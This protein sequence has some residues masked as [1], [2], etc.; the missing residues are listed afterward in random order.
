MAITFKHI[1]EDTSEEVASMEN[2]TVEI[3]IVEAQQDMGMQ[4]DPRI[5]GAEF[6]ARCR[7]AATAMHFFHLITPSY[8]AHVAAQEFYEGIIP[9]MD[10]VAEDM[11]GRFGRFEG[12][13]NVK[14]S[15]LDGLQICGNAAKWLDA[16][17]A[18]MG[19]YSEIQNGIDAVLSLTNSTAFKLRDLK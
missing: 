2:D 10:A 14:E 18:L 15:S 3:E 7:A 11:I 9:L 4:Q 16:N 6:V 19:E 5:K 8:A 13:P 17:R 1:Y 12:F